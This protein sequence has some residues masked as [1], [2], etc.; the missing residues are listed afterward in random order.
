MSGQLGRIATNIT[1]LTGLFN[2]NQVNNKLSA[3]IN[4]LSTG[5]R[6]NGAGDDAAGF[7]IARTMDVKINSLSASQSNAQDAINLLQVGESQQGRAQDLLI[8]I[9]ADLQRAASGTI[10]DAERVAI[11]TKL[12]QFLSE[13]HDI[14]SRTEFNGVKLLSAASTNFIVQVGQKGSESLTT[15]ISGV[16][17]RTLGLSGLTCSTRAHALSALSMIQVAVSHL[18]IRRENIGAG[19]ARLTQK[20]SALATDQLNT[21]SSRSVIQDADIAAE[22]VSLARSNILQQ[23]A[24]SVLGQANNSPQT[25]LNLLPRQ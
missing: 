2:L 5:K 20:L 19:I 17:P 7:A 14:A 15:T 18:T 25:L 4:R 8:E 21:E 9:T 12:T 22:E 6:I 23:T 11:N 16:S 10:G 24:L 13:I 1:A 3:T